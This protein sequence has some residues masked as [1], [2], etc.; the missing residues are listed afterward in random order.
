[1]RPTRSSSRGFRGQLRLWWVLDRMRALNARGEDRAILALGQEFLARWKGNADFYARM[2]GAHWG[3]SHA[4]E[5]VRCAR[6]A[7]RLEPKRVDAAVYLLAAYRSLDANRGIR[8]GTGWVAR[9]RADPEICRHLSFLYDDL[10]RPKEALAMA[11]AG[12]RRGRRD[13]RLI[14]CIANYLAKVEGAESALR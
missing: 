10:D 12:L 11:R 14:G 1:M 5:A 3:L 9:W 7:L 6:L 2:A 4:R 8:F 13:A